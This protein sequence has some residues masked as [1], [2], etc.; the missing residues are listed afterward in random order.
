MPPE[1][2]RA[3]GNE[4]DKWPVKFEARDFVKPAEQRDTLGTL[5]KDDDDDGFRGR[6]LKI[7]FY[8]PLL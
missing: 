6:C 3:P 1:E 2:K 5:S 4:V 7:L 8:L